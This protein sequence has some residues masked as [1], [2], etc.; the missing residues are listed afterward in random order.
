VEFGSKFQ[1]GAKPR[2]N[3]DPNSSWEQCQSLIWSQIPAW[4]EREVEFAFKFQLGAK[5]RWNLDQ[6]FQLGAKPRWNLD[7]NSSWEQSQGR[8]CVQMSAGGKTEMEFTKNIPPE[9][10]AE[11]EFVSKLQLGVK[12]RWNL[13][14]NYSWRQSRGEIWIQIPA[15]SEAEMEFASK[16]HLGTKPRWNLD[17]NSRSGRSLG[18]IWISILAWGER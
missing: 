17:P 10:E 9:F 4:G 5:P 7:P 2:W 1:L 13:R 8:I 3:I 18:G 16:F 6:K 15:G 12:P 11:V 14:L